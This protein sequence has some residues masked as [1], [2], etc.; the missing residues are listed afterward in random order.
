MCQNRAIA[1]EME[2]NQ[3]FPGVKVEYGGRKM[4]VV[5]KGQQR[6][7]C[8]GNTDLYLDWCAATIAYTCNKVAQSLPYLHTKG[9]I[10][11]SETEEI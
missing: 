11:T 10:S 2:T 4:D 5:I 9:Q 8:V 3:Q 1:I 7:S 6:D